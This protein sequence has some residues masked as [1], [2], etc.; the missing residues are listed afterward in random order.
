VTAAGRALLVVEP[1]FLDEHVGVLRVIAHYYNRLSSLGM[2]VDFAV[3]ADGRLTLLD[4]PSSRTVV[5]R[6]STPR[7]GT[8]SPTWRSG[9]GWHAGRPPA[10]DRAQSRATVLGLAGTCHAVEYDVSMLTNPWLCDRLMPD[11][12]FTHGYVHDLVPNLLLAH[13]LDV[14]AAYHGFAFAGAHHRGYAY[15]L[16]HVG[17]VLCNSQSTADDFL[18]VYGET[19]PPVSVDVPFVPDAGAPTNDRWASPPEGSTRLLLVNALDLRKNILRMEAALL[20]APWKR[21]VHLDVVGR[22]RMPAGQ[23]EQVLTNLAAAGMSVHWYRGASDA[24]LVELY[25]TSDGLLFTSLYEGL[26]LP[27]LEAQ[28]C[29]LPTVSSDTSS[30]REISLNDVLRVDPLDVDQT[31][32]AIVRIAERDERVLAGAALRTAQREWLSTRNGWTGR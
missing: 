6:L 20:A 9:E 25:S 27:I 3:P 31:A 23:A 24:R 12:Q 4:E 16:D 1:T 8:S 2:S 17:H 29:G 11:E 5:T 15:Y 10:P 22:E 19:A 28:S 30:C 26:G 13:A 32:E 14:G 7:T 21:P 18:T